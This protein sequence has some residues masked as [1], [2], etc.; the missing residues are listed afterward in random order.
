MVRQVELFCLYMSRNL[1]NK[2]SCCKQKFRYSCT[3]LSSTLPIV[4]RI[5]SRSKLT[6]T[7]GRH[8]TRFTLYEIEVNKR[9]DTAFLLFF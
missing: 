5:V 1:M 9:L 4:L 7:S 6:E 3:V 8:T 2:S